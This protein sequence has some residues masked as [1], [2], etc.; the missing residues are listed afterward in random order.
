MANGDRCAAYRVLHPPIASVSDC[1][2]ASCCC[3][4]SGVGSPGCSNHGGC[5]CRRP[6][7]VADVSSSS[8]RHG[9]FIDA[10]VARGAHLHHSDRFWRS[11]GSCLTAVAASSTLPTTWAISTSRTPR[12]YAQISHPLSEQVFRELERHPKL[13]RIA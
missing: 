5:T 13:V 2:F 9:D 11:V 7:G 12:I 4:I 1:I 10:S 8:A 6:F 3:C